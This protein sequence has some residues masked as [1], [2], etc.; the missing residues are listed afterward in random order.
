[1]VGDVTMGGLS[2]E[3]WH[4]WPLASGGVLTL[5]PLPH[6]DFFQVTCATAPG[7]DLAEHIE[8]T[9][10]HRV[11]EV[12]VSSS[13]TPHARMVE[14]YRVGRVFLAGD[15]AHVHPPAGGQGLNTGVQD[16]WNLGWKLAWALRGG[17]ESSS[18]ATKPRLPSPPP[19]ST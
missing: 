7:R 9:T 17:P 3:N 8:R 10:K 1:M 13:Y 12:L 2:R 11:E 4:V 14:R 5:C 6:T 19:C 16:A 18:R 15:A